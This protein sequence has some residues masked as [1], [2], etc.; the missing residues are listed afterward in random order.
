MDSKRAFLKHW[1]CVLTLSDLSAY[2]QDFDSHLVGQAHLIQMSLN[3]DGAV[4]GNDADLKRERAQSF[5]LLWL[6]SALH[7]PMNV[8]LT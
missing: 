3:G 6:V 2:V 1:K 4:I 7:C 5:K 8:L